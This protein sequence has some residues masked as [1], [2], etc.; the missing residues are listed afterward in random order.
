MG[1]EVGTGASVVSV[2]LGGRAGGVVEVAPGVPERVVSCVVVVIK[3]VAVPQSVAGGVETGVVV[4]PTW[5]VTGVGD[6][7]MVVG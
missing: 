2:V 1:V 6:S 4:G 5:R 3:V 7:E